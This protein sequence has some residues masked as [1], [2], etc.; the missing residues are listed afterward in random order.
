MPVSF[1]VGESKVFSG[2]DEC[3]VRIPKSTEK[4]RSGKKIAAAKR[5]KD[6][7]MDGSSGSLIDGDVIDSMQHN[8]STP[9]SGHIKKSKSIVSEKASAKKGKTKFFEG[10]SLIDGDVIDSTQHTFSTP[11][12]GHR[13]KIKSIVSE[14]ASSKKGKTK[15][16]EGG[17]DTD[18]VKGSTKIVKNKLRFYKHY[19]IT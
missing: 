11:A 1:E 2:D 8:F 6:S 18:R 10:A 14:K 19:C 17:A 3:V 13:K 16:L 4:S 5:R 15:N 12:S 7:V 9:A